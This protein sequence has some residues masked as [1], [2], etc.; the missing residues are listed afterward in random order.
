MISQREHLKNIMA[1]MAR[2]R[3]VGHR[4]EFNPLDKTATP[5]PVSFGSSR[6]SYPDPDGVLNLS[7]TDAELFG[8][9]PHSKT[10]YHQS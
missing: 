1:D 7:K 4:L 3:D 2:G 5:V 9:L 8:G 6:L 10:I